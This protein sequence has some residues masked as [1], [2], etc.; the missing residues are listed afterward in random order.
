MEIVTV[1]SVCFSLVFLYRE[2]SIAISTIDLLSR[3]CMVAAIKEK[4]TDKTVTIFF[5]A[6]ALE[7]II[8]GTKV[9]YV[10]S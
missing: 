8:F 6:R 10:F 7:C 4:Q 5:S 2:W 3:L 9:E 1:L